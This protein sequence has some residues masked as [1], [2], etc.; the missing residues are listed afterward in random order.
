[1]A[2]SDQIGV[3]LSVRRKVIMPLAL[4]VSIV[5]ARALSAR[6]KTSVGRMQSPAYYETTLW[7]SFLG[8]SSSLLVVRAV[9]VGLIDVIFIHGFP[10]RGQTVRRRRNSNDQ[11]TG[12]CCDAG[13]TSWTGSRFDRCVI[14]IH[15]FPLLVLFRL[16]S[17]V[18]IGFS[19]QKTEFSSVE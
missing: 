19:G 18:E 6:H 8:G 11:I 2:K 12:P 7:G 4:A 15:A 1:M 13:S 5:K 9:A 16:S 17:R 3:Q 14:F 10:W